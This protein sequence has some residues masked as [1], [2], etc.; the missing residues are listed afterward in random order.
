MVRH[1]IVGDFV[2]P[3]ILFLLLAVHF[4]I[5]QEPCRAF[6]WGA[7]TLLLAVLLAACYRASDHIA[8]IL[9]MAEDAIGSVEMHTPDLTRDGVAKRMAVQ[10]IELRENL[11][12]GIIAG[13]L[14]VVSLAIGYMGLPDVKVWRIH[15]LGQSYAFAASLFFLYVLARAAVDSVLSATWI[16][17]F[18]DEL[19]RA[20]E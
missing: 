5:T 18:R 16:N 2:M 7:L 14:L 13:L 12:V 20:L 4:D 6:F 9:K 19:A 17:K 8:L 1:R 3:S 11:V 10:D 15:V